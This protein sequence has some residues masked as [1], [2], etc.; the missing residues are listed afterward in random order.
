MHKLV[1]ISVFVM[2]PHL[3]AAQV[4]AVLGKCIVANIT[5]EDRQDLARWV[6]TSM[7]SY[8]EIEPLTSTHTQATET[9]ARKIGILFT[10]I[11]RD[12]CA[13]EVQEAARVGEQPVVRSAISFFTQLG[14]QQLM[15]N[16]DVL[17]TLS[18]F[19]Q[20][21]DK[22]GIDRATRTK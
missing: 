1:A 8:P 5:P 11:M 20:F 10:R 12:T 14:V 4:P 22:E 9:V 7:A 17:V 3:C 6:F 19:A 2:L 13:K 21:A 16:K 15:S 18:S